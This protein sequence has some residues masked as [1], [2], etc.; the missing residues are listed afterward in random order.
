MTPVSTVG[1]SVAVQVSVRL[2]TAWNED[3]AGGVVI[4]MSDDESKNVYV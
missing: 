1:G 4:S 3:T 2:E